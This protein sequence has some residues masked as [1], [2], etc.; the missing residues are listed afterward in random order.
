MVQP[1]TLV[2]VTLIVAVPA[3]SAFHAIVL[4][5]LTP[6]IMPCPVIDHEYVAPGPASVTE[7]VWPVDSAQTA[8]GVVMVESGRGFTMTLVVLVSVTPVLVVTVRV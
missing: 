5:S 7:A 4:V 6:V 3:L 8:D 2:T 1:Q